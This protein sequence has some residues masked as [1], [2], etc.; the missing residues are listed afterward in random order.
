MLHNTVF[1]DTNPSVYLSVVKSGLLD[2][3]PTD[4]PICYAIN[5]QIIQIH[6]RTTL[7]S[8]NIY[9]N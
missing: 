4:I 5:L 1:W 7:S 9:Y 2:W 6:E 3:P 8:S